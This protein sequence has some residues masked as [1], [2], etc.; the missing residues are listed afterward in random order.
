MTGGGVRAA[1]AAPTGAGGFDRP[2]RAASVLTHRRPEE[3]AAALI[4][5]GELA[6]AS[7]VT[8]Q[9]SAEEAAKHPALA[10]DPTVVGGVAPD[11]PADLCFAF[12]GDGTILN[13]L[14]TYAG[15]GV[16]VFAIN[17]GEMGF[18]ATVDRED[19]AAGCARALAGDFEVLSLPGI[20]VSGERGRWLA[21]NDLSM[22]RQQGKRVA[23]LGFSSAATRWGGC[24][25]TA[26]W[27]P[28]RPARRATTWPTAGR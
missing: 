16:P 17:F 19:A 2:I 23:D 27:W 7:G 5:L 14:R 3:T 26:W 4:A 24:V 9:L 6:R 22:H 12:G 21:I 10:A 25:A 28:R 11:R 18:L 8:L 15:T 1:G 13:A 20:E